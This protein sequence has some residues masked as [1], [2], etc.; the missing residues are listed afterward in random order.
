[1]K[2]YE[3]LNL[4]EVN[5]WAG[6]SKVKNTIINAGLEEEFNNLID[7]LYP[8]GLSITKLNDLLRFDYE[9]IFECLGIEYDED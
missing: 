5:T 9:Y 7:E 4:S 3:E 1:M 6:A 8:E 2:I